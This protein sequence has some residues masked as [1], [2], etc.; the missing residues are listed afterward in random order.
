MGGA[1]RNFYICFFL[2]MARMTK[3]NIYILS[4]DKNKSNFQKTV[5]VKFSGLYDFKLFQYILEDYFQS[6]ASES[7]QV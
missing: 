6:T 1:I 4:G 3:K 2:Q 7:D 5:K